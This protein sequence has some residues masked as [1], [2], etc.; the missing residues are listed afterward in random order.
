MRIAGPGHENLPSRRGMDRPDGADHA[1]ISGDIDAATAT[2]ESPGARQDL[3]KPEFL[4]R[5]GRSSVGVANTR[6]GLSHMPDDLA[7]L[8]FGVVGELQPIRRSSEP[9]YLPTQNAF[10]AKL[11]ALASEEVCVGLTHTDAPL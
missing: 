10:L 8:P 6:G 5:Q 7:C 3:K 11:P 4:M 9:G 1:W 2:R